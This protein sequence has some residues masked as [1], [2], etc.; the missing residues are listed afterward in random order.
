MTSS[1]KR[2]W[3][4]MNVPRLVLTV[5]VYDSPVRPWTLVTERTGS[6]RVMFEPSATDCQNSSSV[7]TT[8]MPTASTSELE[9]FPCSVSLPRRIRAQEATTGLRQ[10]RGRAP[11]R[12]VTHNCHQFFVSRA[13][14]G[15]P[16]TRRVRTHVFFRL[17][18]S[19]QEVVVAVVDLRAGRQEYEL[20]RGAKTG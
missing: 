14:I 7:G 13:L 12:R 5:I 3:S 6:E 15:V 20:P 4:K 18:Q 17:P 1:S 8:E 11:P 10:N 9:S 16:S 2:S 19:S